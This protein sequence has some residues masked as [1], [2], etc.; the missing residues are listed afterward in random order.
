MQHQAEYGLN[1][2]EAAYLC[3]SLFGAGSDTTSAA[4][5]V[6]VMAAARFPEAQKKAQEQLDLVVGQD[7]MPSFGDLDDLPY[8]NAFVLESY[9]WRPVSAGGF[10]HRATE[11]I[12]YNGYLIPKGASVVGNHWGIFRDPSV[13]P[14]PE[15]FKPERW[16]TEEGRVRDDLKN[17][18]FGFGRRICPGQH[19]ANRSVLIN[20]ADIL[21]SFRI[22]QNP[23]KPIDVFG[24]TDTANSHPLPFEVRFE[25]RFGSVERVIKEAEISK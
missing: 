19:V 14:S 15:L 2:D 13:F 22:S 5:M 10:V 9:R 8:V 25:Q 21:W 6:L 1:D 23:N 17:F 11:D 4:I 12:Q 20:A 3:G 24:F 7:R 16:L 18:N